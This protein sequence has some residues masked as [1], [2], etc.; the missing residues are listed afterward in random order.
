[1]TLSTFSACARRTGCPARRFPLTRFLQE[2]AMRLATTDAGTRK[3]FPSNLERMTRAIHSIFR[4]LL[5]VVPCAALHA[6]D[7]F[8]APLPK[9]ADIEIRRDIAFTPSGET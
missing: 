1:G 4:T 6:Q 8:M 7:R 2:G 5:L 3:R 9:D